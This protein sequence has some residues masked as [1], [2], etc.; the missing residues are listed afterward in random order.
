LLTGNPGNKGGTGRPP[1]WLREWCDERLA[2]PTAKD[3]VELI[4]SNPKN[5][6]FVPM[7]KAVADRAHGKPLQTLDANL[8]VRLEDIV[9]E[10]R[11]LA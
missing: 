1:N 2:D 9:A 3:A 11:Q 5:P 7:W 6:A 4:L 10:S 8:T